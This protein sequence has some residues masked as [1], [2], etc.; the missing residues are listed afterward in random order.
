MRLSPEE[1]L[2]RL[3]EELSLLKKSEL[4]IVE[5]INDKKALKAFGIKRIITLA[6]PLYKVIESCEREAAVLTDLDREGKMLYSK[7]RSELSRRGVKINDRFRNFLF[8]STKLRQI[9]G[10]ENYINRLKQR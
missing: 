10:L 2:E 8:S 6:Q 9:E 3:E 5:G 4:V 7:I 1:E